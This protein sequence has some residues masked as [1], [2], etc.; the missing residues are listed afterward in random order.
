[1]TTRLIITRSFGKWSGGTVVELIG[2]KGDDAIVHHVPTK[3]K[4]NIPL[5][6]LVVKRNR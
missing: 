5:D 1:M 2:K 4:F 3:E 6:Y